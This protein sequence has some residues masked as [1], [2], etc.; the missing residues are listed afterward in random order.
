MTGTTTSDDKVKDGGK[1][2]LCSCLV[3]FH[4]LDFK[5]S[6][7]LRILTAL[8]MQHWLNSTKGHAAGEHDN[9]NNNHDKRQGWRGR[10]P[11]LL[12]TT[13]PS[14]WLQAN[15]G[16]QQHPDILL[17]M[18]LALAGMPVIYYCLRNPDSPAL[19][20]L[21]SPTPV[22][23]ALKAEQRLTG[24]AGE[25]KRGRVSTQSCWAGWP[26]NSHLSGLGVYSQ[27]LTICHAGQV[28]HVY[29]M[30]L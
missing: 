26:S 11:L 13:L 1:A 6:R 10:G 19:T 24:E 4:Q 27:L 25:K 22:A 7:G 23:A 17:H 21:D 20:I 3:G 2:G 12:L 5:P 28:E 30:T 16:L 8:L 29:I 18:H 9:S 14:A 15:C